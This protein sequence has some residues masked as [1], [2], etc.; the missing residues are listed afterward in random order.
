MLSFPIGIDVKGEYQADVTP[1]PFV[2]SHGGELRIMRKMPLKCVA[3]LI[4]SAL[5]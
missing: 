3:Y 5:T 1:H 4:L 2:P